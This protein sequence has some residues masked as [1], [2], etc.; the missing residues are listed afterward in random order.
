ME[1]GA[2]PRP[3][4]DLWAW[5]WP[6]GWGRSLA[7]W[8]T[9][10]ASALSPGAA[11]GWRGAARRPAGPWPGRGSFLLKRKERGCY[12]DPLAEEH[13]LLHLP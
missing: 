13:L 2:F 11:P 5:P 1:A 10:P 8:E 4:T 6:A 12:G 3:G 9:P 7:C